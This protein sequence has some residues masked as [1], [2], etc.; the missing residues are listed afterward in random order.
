[1]STSSTDLPEVAKAICVKRGFTFVRGIG[2]GAFKRAF[3]VTQAGTDLALKLIASGGVD[4]LVREI[5]TA[6]RCSHPNIGRLR[7]V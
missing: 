4:R 3:H 1:M 5:G 6:S 2:G 7:K